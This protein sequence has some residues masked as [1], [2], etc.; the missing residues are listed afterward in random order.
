MYATREP[1]EAFHRRIGFT[2]DVH[3]EATR[4]LRFPP[5]AHR[6]DLESAEARRD[7]ER[8]EEELVKEIEEME[9]DDEDGGMADDGPGM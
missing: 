6:E 7:R 4:G 5:G 1:Q 9:D 3:N 8:A 2:L